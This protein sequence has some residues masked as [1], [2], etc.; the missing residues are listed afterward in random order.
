MPSQSRT[1]AIVWAVLTGLTLLSWQLSTPHDVALSSNVVITLGVLLMGYV[2]CR[3]IIQHF[4][5]VR[6]SRR[7]LRLFSEIWL[8]GLFGVIALIYLYGTRTAD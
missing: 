7:D 8:I 5:E 1:L 2:K 3:L 6:S 4:M